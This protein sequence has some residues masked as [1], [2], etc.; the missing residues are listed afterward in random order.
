[1]I[2]KIKEGIVKI[3]KKGAK[4][5]SNVQVLVTAGPTSFWGFLFIIIPL[6][7]ILYYSFLTSG[8]YGEIKPTVTFEN[9]LNVFKGQYGRIFLRSLIFAIVT[10]LLCM[11]IGY[12]L[13]YWIAMYAGR[14][15]GILMA[16]VVIPSWTAYLLRIYAL[17]TLFRRTGLINNLLQSLNLI[18]EP[19]HL[20]YTPASVIV[21]L[22]YTWLPF[23]VL[24][25]YAA[26]SDLN[27]SW[28]EAAS[29]LGAS[30]RIRFFKVTLPLTR[31]G[32]FAGSILVFAPALG[33]YLVPYFLGGGKTMMVGSLIAHKMTVVGNIPLACALSIILAITVISMLLLYIKLTG[34]EA[35]ER[36]I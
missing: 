25:L 6:M 36:L 18:V 23:M 4:G 5:L 15:K 26:V 30:P 14:W 29:D 21:G 28:L 27:L 1:M 12:P 2:S 7:I 33:S 32:L 24:P 17:T 16:L 31:G 13:A 22:V 3:S 8:P 20:L 35:F 34:E 11:L 10:T 9:V 19:L